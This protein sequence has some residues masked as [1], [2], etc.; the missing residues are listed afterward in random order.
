MALIDDLLLQAQRDLSA[1]ETE[2]VARLINSYGLALRRIE[3][4]LR[5]I[6]AQIAELAAQGQPVPA[7]W[8]TR[9]R[10]WRDM[11]RSIQRELLL[12]Q[13]QALNGLSAL[14]TGGVHVGVGLSGDIAKAAGQPLTGQ[15]Y[16]E[17]FERW[18]TVTQPGSPVR[19]VIDG[20]GSRASESILQRMTEGIG[21]GKAPRSIVR[22]IMADIGGTGSEARL[23]TLARTET[24]RAFRGANADTLAPLQE[25][26]IIIGY[27]WIASLDSRTCPACLE[28]HGRLFKEYPDGHH[29]NCRCVIRPE[30]SQD[31][32]P[33]GGWKGKTGPEWFDEQPETV[34]R[35]ILVSELRYDAY[36]AGTPLS[37]MVT[38]RH[39]AIW[40]DSIAVRPVGQLVA[41][42]AA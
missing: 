32:V 13:G 36:H 2:I 20:Y 27:R 39:S 11:E 23:M 28:R 30:V 14:Q 37:E 41:G 21:G 15:V 26:G 42:R 31:I 4:N 40:G 24:M 35:S 3:R 1:R 38:T 34:Q 5:T 25:Q 17:A 10:W 9:Q 19:A 7:T 12:W 33:G 8:L 29:P 18:V 22:E 16:R 6:D